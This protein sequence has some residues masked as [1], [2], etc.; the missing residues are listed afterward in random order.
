MQLLNP[1]LI[2]NNV[3]SF[4]SQLYKSVFQIDKCSNFFE[5]V[6]LFASPISTQFR[7]LCDEELRQYEM[8]TAIHSIKK[9][10]SRQVQMVFQWSFIFVSGI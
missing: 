10:I 6:K 4:Y 9:K 7:D 5:S 3:E 8:V 1:K 2:S